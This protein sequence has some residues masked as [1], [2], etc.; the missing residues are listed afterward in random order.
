VRRPPRIAVAGN[1]N[2]D[3]SYRVDRVPGQGETLLAH[4]LTIGPGGKA[5]NA[6]VALAR[7]KAEPQLIGCVGEDALGKIVLAALERDGVGTDRIVRR[8]DCPTGV[9]TVLVLPC[10]ENAIVTHLGANLELQAGELPRL[11]GCRAL[12]MT[13]GLAHETLRELARKA[14]ALGVTLVVDATPLRAAGPPREVLGADVLSANEGEAEL[15]IGHAI[16][17][18][19]EL[20]A[21]D[22]CAELRALGASAA[23][24]KLGAR[25]AAWADGAA[26][27]WVRAP[28]VRAVDTTGCGDAFMAGLT[29]R[30]VEGAGLREAVEFACLL[31]ALNATARGA[32]GGWSAPADVYRF[33]ATVS[34]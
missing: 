16:D 9:A 4:D 10:A 30:L 13:L 31:G 19:D 18:E 11:E 17:G 6:S 5:C 2:A 3:L 21:T 1:V 34:V 23:V 22:A 7:L 25:G 26:H 8:A 15:L 12:L 32:Q 27:G 24:L 29:L 14:R 33:A 20:A 28:A